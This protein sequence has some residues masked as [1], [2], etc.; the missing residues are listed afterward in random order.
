M[1]GI[2]QCRC[3]VELHFQLINQVRRHNAA[4][5]ARVRLCDARFHCV[6]R[7]ADAHHAGHARAALERVQQTL[8]RF[9]IAPVTAVAAPIAERGGDGRDQ[10]LA[11]FKKQR[12]QI[13]V[14]LSALYGARRKR[15]TGYWYWCGG[16]GLHCLQQRRQFI[17][18]CREILLRYLSHHCCQTLQCQ[19]QRCVLRRIRRH[20]NQ[21]E[22]FQRQL[23]CLRQI[24]QRCDAER[25]RGTGE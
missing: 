4:I 5:A 8:Q 18:G 21:R 19:P 12:Q 15:N 7:F 6:H 23:Q 14:D 13:V 22:T 24:L 20:A 11:L 10:F 3:L 9:G 2:N 1:Q 25:G 17:I 16:N